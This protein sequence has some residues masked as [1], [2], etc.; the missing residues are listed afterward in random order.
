ME[1][2]GPEGEVIKTMPAL[3]IDAEELSRGLDILADAAESVA[4][5]KVAVKSIA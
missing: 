4:G 2:S 5:G 3:T 1:T